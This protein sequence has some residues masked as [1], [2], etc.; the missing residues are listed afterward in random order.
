MLGE[1]LTQAKEGLGAVRV[2]T[3]PSG[4]GKTL[5]LQHAASVARELGF[6]VRW[7]HALEG[8]TGPFFLL[9]QLLPLGKSAGSGS[10]PGSSDGA[11]DRHAGDRGRLSSILA[12]GA[13]EEEEED[14][15]GSLLEPASGRPASSADVV[16]P[17]PPPGGML[18]LGLAASLSAPRPV[19]E[20]TALLGYLHRLEELARNC[21]QL[22]VV[23]DLQWGDVASLHGLRF[24]ARNA[25]HLPV[26]LLASARAEGRRVG[27]EIDREI[28][29]GTFLDEAERIDRRAIVPLAPL[30]A[31]PAHRLV[32]EVL[33]G[34][35]ATPVDARPFRQL[36]E[37]SGGNPLILSETV[38]S[39]VLEG[40]ARRERGRWTL[41]TPPAWERR[42]ERGSGAHGAADLGGSGAPRKAAGSLPAPSTLTRAVL[43]RLTGLPPQLREALQLGAVLGPRFDLEPVAGALQMPVED[44]AREVGPLTAPGGLL[45]RT[46]GP[47]GAFSFSHA[48]LWE[49]IEG[50]ASPSDR[51]ERSRRLADWYV[52]DRPGD[53]MSIARLFHEAG[54]ATQT[55][56]WTRRATEVAL[57]SLD[58]EGLERLGEWLG[59]ALRAQG[60]DSTEAARERFEVVR[61]YLR[62]SGAHP[63]AR[64]ILGSLLSEIAP[65]P[66][67]REVEERLAWVE[68]VRAPKEGRALLERLSR[69]LKGPSER[70][71][72]G[73]PERGL[74]GRVALDWTVLLIREGDFLGA[75]REAHETIEL[76]GG[77]KDRWELGRAYYYLG[78]CLGLQER[79]AE[80]QEAMHRS[81]EIARE[82]HDARLL[83][84]T[85]ELQG[86]LA[87]VRGAVLEAR[88]AMTEA[89]Q[90]HRR[91]GAIHNIISTLGNLA[92]AEADL[93]QTTDAWKRTQEMLSLARRFDDRRGIAHASLLEGSMWLRAGHP[94]EAR[95]KLQEAF[96]TYQGL[97]DRESTPPCL[98]K[99]A[100]AEA[101]S[102]DAP[103]ALER[104]DAVERGLHGSLSMG[105]RFLLGWARAEA[106]VRSGQGGS[107][108]PAF[109]EA[110]EA[111]REARNPYSEAEVTMAQADWEA[112]AGSPASQVRALRLAAEQLWR[113]CGVDP[114]RTAEARRWPGPQTDTHAPG[115]R[116]RTT[117]SGRRASSAP[118]AQVILL[119]LLRHQGPSGGPSD[120][121]P[122]ALTQ[123]GLSSALGL[124]QA[125]FAKTLARLVERGLVSSE[126]RRIEGHARRLKTYRA[127]PAGEAVAAEMTQG[128]VPPG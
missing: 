89:L 83:G 47:G 88:N 58:V 12:L 67:H 108:R 121:V 26:V 7:S 103:R 82:L 99:L 24:L 10:G 20:A 106:L 77:G 117:L 65:G 21:P 62:S 91:A 110:R 19:P 17:S 97:G 60:V 79:H 18:P 84:L 87:S 13:S 125:R 15:D 102:G 50:A 54:A 116:G 124:P 49:T 56:A 30:V 63:V 118:L 93:G 36:I 66:L 1:A 57:A 45:V 11:S 73:D 128:H 127:T 22:L 98:L 81:M 92:E 3:G 48:L 9:D 2:L 34:P 35:L 113:S 29:P 5:L 95:S 86:M 6:E 100:R 44:L 27:A 42:V 39:M 14:E 31:A 28:G 23:D 107:A 32:E 61:T 69:E 80:A 78:W 64:R 112:G 25:G 52:R 40:F 37:R 85:L 55:V 126:V 96:Q 43:S 59:E 111:A 120:R 8:W 104:I 123:V 53:P 105:E 122:V 119:H 41:A 109:E 51:R 76:L 94:L 46:E 71:P 38:R 68:M 70:G 74:R 4:I 72:E 90:Q 115:P 75:L 114:K 101:L 16:G 33:G